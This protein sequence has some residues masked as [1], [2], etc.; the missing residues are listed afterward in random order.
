MN[1]GRHLCQSLGEEKARTHCPAGQ[2]EAGREAGPASQQGRGG[3]ERRQS[4]TP[5]TPDQGSKRYTTLLASGSPGPSSPFPTLSSDC[6]QLVS[7]RQ[8]KRVKLH[9]GEPQKNCRAQLLSWR[10]AQMAKLGSSPTQLGLAKEIRSRKWRST[11]V[12][13]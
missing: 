6:S 2:Q 11:L 5:A 8:S 10:V 4:L 9:Y 7:E 13:I 1:K 12:F 3:T